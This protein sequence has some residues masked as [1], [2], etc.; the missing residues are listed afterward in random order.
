ML[1]II[2]AFLFVV[3]FLILSLPIQGIFFLLGKNPKWKPA[4]DKASLHIVQ[5]AFKVI[6]VLSGA[7]VKEI[8]REN[9]PKDQPVLFVGNHQSFFDVILTYSRMTDLTGYISK[10]EFEKTPLLPIWMRRLYCLF[11]DRKDIRQ[12]MQVI[13]T[14]AEYVK[15]G[16]SIFIFPEGTRSKDGKIHEFKKGSFKIAQKTGCPI[17]PVSIRGT[18]DIFENHFPTLKPGD[19]TITYGKPI[20]MSELDDE[21]K[22]HIDDY[23]RD[24][25]VEAV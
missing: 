16:V 18:A 22:K 3:V 10:K 6:E 24:V 7:R 2:I 5:W 9:I 25:I 13:L 15:S 8:G 14:A 4:I 11:I 17:V 12:S 19:V 20:I 1:R 21:K 23:V